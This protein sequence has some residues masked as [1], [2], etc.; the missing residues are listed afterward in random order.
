MLARILAI[1]LLSTFVFF[2]QAE[3]T[4][5]PLAQATMFAFGGVG[6]AG[7]RSQGEKDYRDVMSR[8]NR[9]EILEQVFE[10]GTPAAKGYALVGI[11]NLDHARFTALAEP[12]R[13]S[14]QTVRSMRGCIIFRTTLAIIIRDIDA[15]AYARYLS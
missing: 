11:S 9:L 6:F 4:V 10:T 12:L 14:T 13:S 15:G 7:K 8:P 1:I 2:G 5:E 3:P